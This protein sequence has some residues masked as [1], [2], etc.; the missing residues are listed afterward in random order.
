M[1]QN[2]SAFVKYFGSVR[3]RTNLYAKAIPPDQIDWSP[4]VDEL[5]CAA[6]LLHLVAAEN[7]FVGEL[8]TGEWHYTEPEHQPGISLEEILSLLQANHQEAMATLQTLDDAVLFQP[9]STLK[10]PEMKGWRLLMAMVEHEVH[11]RS[12]LAVYLSLMG[13]EPPQIFG[14]KLEE[15]IEITSER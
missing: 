1:I 4:K 15:I 8:A 9:H 6:I 14:L 5:T 3:R 7:M 13:V 11:H 12:Q 10:G 2:I